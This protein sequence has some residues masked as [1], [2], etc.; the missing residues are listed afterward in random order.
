MKK[1]ILNPYKV[2]WKMYGLIGGISVLVMI[3]AVSWNNDT[4]SS[5]SDVIKNLAFGCVASTL[6]ALSIEIGNT[7]E[8]MK[9]QIVYIMQYF[10]N[11]NI[12]Y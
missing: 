9:K 6:V 5:I 8:K 12:E 10:L 1:H 7:K 3:F 2:N 4:N 11:Y